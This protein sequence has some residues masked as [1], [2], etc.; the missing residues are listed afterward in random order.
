M[1]NL[2]IPCKTPVIAGRFPLL[3]VRTPHPGRCTDSLSS[4][5]REIAV[6]QSSGSVVADQAATSIV[7][8]PGGSPPI[9][10]CAAMSSPEKFTATSTAASAPATEYARTR[11]AGLAWADTGLRVADVDGYRCDAAWGVQER[12]PGFWAQWRA[13]LQRIRPVCCCWRSRRRGHVRARRQQLRWRLGPGGDRG[14]R[15]APRG[16]AEQNPAPAASAVRRVNVRSVTRARIP[17]AQLVAA[18]F[19]NTAAIP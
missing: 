1:Q 4:C 2:A 5:E 18:T 19:S 15:P 12:A 10:I 14:A 3:L 11:S 8:T 7:R 13:E 6:C 17:L 9:S 16:G